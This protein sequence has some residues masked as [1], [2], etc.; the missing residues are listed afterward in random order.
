MATARERRWLYASGFVRSMATSTAGV[1][2][3]SFLGALDAW[4][5]TRLGG[6]GRARRRCGGCGNRDVLRRSDRRFRFLVITSAI[7]VAGTIA[8]ALAES[9]VALVAAAFLRP[10]EERRTS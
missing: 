3:G 1:T 9:P 4:R 10:P 8:F 6:L 5:S 2:V 7:G